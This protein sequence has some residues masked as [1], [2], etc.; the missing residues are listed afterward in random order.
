MIILIL[1]SDPL[2]ASA[3]KSTGCFRDENRKPNT[4]F[5]SASSMKS[6]HEL[7]PSNVCYYSTLP[8]DYKSFARVKKATSHYDVTSDCRQNAFG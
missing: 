4:E 7:V 3:F 6:P 1:I 2:A 5:R 8:F